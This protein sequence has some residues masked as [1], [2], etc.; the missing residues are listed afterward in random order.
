[1]SPTAPHAPLSKYVATPAERQRFVIDLFDRSA[2][3]YDRIC[4]VMSFGSGLRYRHGALV[5][6]GL[7]SGMHVLDVATGTGLVARAALAIVGGHGRVIGLDPSAGMLTRAREDITRRL[8][9]GLG[10]SLP[11]A[12]GSFDFVSMG[13]ALRHVDHLETAFTE[14]R[15]VLKPGGR[16]LL[17]EITPPRSRA[18]RVAA[19][20][21]F[22][23]IVP[24]M[25]RA[26]THSADG[27]RL[28]QYYWDTI[29]ACVPPE[30]IMSALT[31]VGFDNVERQVVQGIFSEYRAENRG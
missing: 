14:Y 20:L 25:T 4:E 22:K 23:R 9:R 17:L 26:I 29:E 30:M 24:L 13:Y 10:D 5:R 6:G 18:G 2:P 19:R 1:M 7:K 16:V 12:S 11:I 31:R 27:V 21:Y 28:M 3:F 15:R 8:V